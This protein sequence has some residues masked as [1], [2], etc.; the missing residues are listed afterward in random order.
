MLYIIMKQ[1]INRKNKIYNL[2]KQKQLQRVILEEKK[3]KK[4][5]KRNE[6]E[7]QIRR[8]II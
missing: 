5:N 7:I 6:Y 4:K 1:K 8:T 2:K 3:K